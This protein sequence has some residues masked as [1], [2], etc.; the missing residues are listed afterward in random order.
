MIIDGLDGCKG[1]DNQSR[2]ISYISNI[3]RDH[4]L[5]FTF[6]VVSHPEPHIKN[7]LQNNP[8]IYPITQC[9][10]LN[11]SPEDIRTFLIDRFQ[12]MRN[13]HPSLLTCGDN[14]PP[15]PDIDVLVY[16]SSGYFIYASTAIK[17]IGDEDT[18]P[19]ENLKSI[20]SRKLTPLSALDDI[21]HQIVATVAQ[22]RQP[23][24]HSI[25]AIVMVRSWTTR[26]IGKVL[27]LCVGDVRVALR[28]MHSLLLNIDSDYD[29]IKVVHTSFQDFLAD[30]TQS[31][32]FYVNPSFGHAKIAES[33]IR[34]AS[35]G[36]LIP[37]LSM[38][39]LS[40]VEQ[41]YAEQYI[42]MCN[43]ACCALEYLVHVIVHLQIIFECRERYSQKWNLLCA[44]GEEVQ[45]FAENIFDGRES[46]NPH[47]SYPQSKDV[48]T[49]VHLQTRIYNH[50]QNTSAERI[51][52]QIQDS[53][54]IY[55]ISRWKERILG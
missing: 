29:V 50:V 23:I 11:T 41:G 8:D 49:R 54:K 19:M 18:N 35:F 21:Y 2:L 33:F 52:P 12:T 6:V 3:V 51:N 9:F 32:S 20:I 26:T 46:R 22:S 45:V 14:W 47:I 15:E 7:S 28:R 31:G 44:Q 24:V 4:N 10:K 16:R 55:T 42:K 48:R 13:T 30:K 38:T 37:E 1:D 53:S 43:G 27:G 5:P 40:E 34:Q 39:W 36:V 17:Y 25:P